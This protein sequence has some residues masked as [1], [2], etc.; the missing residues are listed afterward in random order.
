MGA[1]SIIRACAVSSSTS[2]SR[3]PPETAVS[4]AGATSFPNAAATSSVP[5]SKC[6]YSVARAT[7]ASL[8]TASIV[9]ASVPPLTSSVVAASSNRARERAFL[10]SW[11]LADPS[12][13]SVPIRHH[14]LWN[15]QFTYDTDS[16]VS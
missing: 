1:S 6:R 13:S 5:L 9:T 14:L 10:G 7:F 2:C 3:R 16:L 12:L 15:H 4:G 8:V 11:S